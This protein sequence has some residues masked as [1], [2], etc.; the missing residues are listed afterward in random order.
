MACSSSHSTLNADPN[1]ID[2]DDRDAANESTHLLPGDDDEAV[3]SRTRPAPTPL[4]KAQLG[5]LIAVRIVDPIAYQQIFPYINQ[6]LADLRIAEPE[7]V[8]FYSGLVVRMDCLDARLSLL[9]P[10]HDGQTIG[11]C[12]LARAGV[13]GVSVGK[14]IRSVDGLAAL[15]IA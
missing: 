12:I 6:L 7:R 4:P 13:F 2:N 3:S 10:T 14:D 5:A 9:T 8:G 1:H 15:P 11:E